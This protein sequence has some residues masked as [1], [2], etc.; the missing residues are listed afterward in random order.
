MKLQ[1]E[2]LDILK[3]RF[4]E[5]EKTK[6]TE[7][8]YLR[9]AKA[10]VTYGE[11]RELTKEL[12]VEFK[13][14]L[15]QRYKISSANSM[16]AAVNYFLRA[17]GCGEYVVKAFRVQH[18]AFRDKDRELTREEYLRLLAAARG[19]GDMRLYLI[20]QTICATGI[21]I[22]ELPF[23]TVEALNTRR[24]QVSL[25]GKT[26]TVILPMALCRELQRYARK[27][28]IHSGSIF[29]TESGRPVDRSNVL[30]DMKKLS[31]AA[32]VPAEKVFPHNLRHLF[33]VTFY[34]AER[35]VCRLAD[36]LGHSS[37]NT[38]RI[39]T[40]VSCEEQEAQVNALG[41][42]FGVKITS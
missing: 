39:Y 10:F 9:D 7:E 11:G 27:Q 33:A 15:E 30:H 21:R 34:Q 17:I 6:A 13:R 29:I 16:L 36:L 28:R 3:Q 25:K 40:S 20:M 35:D 24:A 8:K 5:D 1:Y 22:S 18:A 32:Q 4:R 23:I 14:Y 38:T 31:E 12:V 41:L 26:R 19:K 42:C 37:I 2:M